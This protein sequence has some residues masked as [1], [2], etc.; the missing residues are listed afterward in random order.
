VAAKLVVVVTSRTELQVMCAELA[1]VLG[2]R[3]AV[4]TRGRVWRQPWIHH[5]GAVA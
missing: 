2:E 3:G 1:L 5:V 4:A